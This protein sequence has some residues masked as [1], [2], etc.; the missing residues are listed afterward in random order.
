MKMK[1]FIRHCLMT[2]LLGGSA[3][4]LAAC[5]SNTT[6]LPLIPPTTP[7]EVFAEVYQAVGQVDPSQVQ[8]V[9]YRDNAPST[10][11]W[12]AA[13]LYIDRE[14]HTGL[15]PN[16]YTTFCLEPGYHTLEAYQDDAPLYTGKTAPQLRADL[17]GGQTYFLKVGSPEN[18]NPQPV[19]RVE[20]EKE[21]VGAQRQVQTVSRAA[22]VQPCNIIG[23][24]VQVYTFNTDVL[25]PFNKHSY[26][27]LLPEGRRA[28]VEFGQK[29]R[30]G[31]VESDS[32][33]VVVGH[34]DPIGNSQYNYRLAQHRAETVQRVLLENSGMSPSK[35]TVISKGDT[36]PVV[37]CSDRGM[38]R[39]ELIQCNQPN[40]R[41]E[42]IQNH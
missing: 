23:P 10:A 31:Q 21:L 38:S 16:G 17:K 2:S 42:L 14:F 6:S 33:I 18:G 27:D 13:H 12:P 7:V 1:P 28:L 37:N 30:E 4:L 36:E 41:V 8:V 32:S 26:S 35:L 25:F 11:N 40:R 29:L 39:A 3:L 20:A 5:S 34:A 9:F 15:L 24:A 19:S 22:A